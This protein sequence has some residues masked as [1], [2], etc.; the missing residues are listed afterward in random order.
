MEDSEVFHSDF[1][2]LTTSA[3][4]KTLAN[5]L[6]EE[7]TTWS[8]KNLSYDDGCKQLDAI[9]TKWDT[10]SVKFEASY[11]FETISPLLEYPQCQHFALWALKVQTTKSCCKYVSKYQKTISPVFCKYLFT[12]DVVNLLTWIELVC[13]GSK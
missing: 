4:S 10:T 12:N 9:P 3:A 6:S 11:S 5:L 8:L 13:F 7:K 2:G 1:P